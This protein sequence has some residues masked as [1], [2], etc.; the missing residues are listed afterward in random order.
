MN[1]NFVKNNGGTYAFIDDS[2]HEHNDVVYNIQALNAMSQEV[3]GSIGLK[4]TILLP[5]PENALD[6]DGTY[7][8]E[9]MQDGT[10]GYRPN[11]TIGY[12]VPE[13]ITKVQAMR[14]MKKYGIWEA[15]NNYLAQNQDAKD[16]WELGSVFER[17]N[18]YTISGAA[19]M[20]ISEQLDALFI[21]GGNS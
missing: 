19:A 20:G 15:F 6:A 4:K 8:F 17:Y 5:M 16:E 12:R 7:Y 3:L 9:E 2:G 1:Y 10:V 13:T 11:Y 18:E 14:V 21:E